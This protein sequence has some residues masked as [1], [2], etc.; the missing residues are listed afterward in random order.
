MTDATP[1]IV[2]RWDSDAFGSTAPNS[3][4]DGDGIHNTLDLRFPGQ[5]YDQ[6]TALH[7]NQ[8]RYYDPSGPRYTQSDPIVLRGG[9]NSYSY[10][11]NNPLFFV[12]PTGLRVACNCIANSE[13]GQY[14]PDP[15]APKGTLGRKRCKYQCTCSCGKCDGSWTPYREFKEV[16]ANGTIG[17][18]TIYG[19]NNTQKCIGQGDIV[20]FAPVFDAFTVSEAF[21]QRYPDLYDSLDKQCKNDDCKK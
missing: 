17:D 7:Y 21:R 1:K 14:F 20:N 3:D 13:G 19:W 9:L 4:P 6:E 15:S 10:A 11:L 2:W 5:I 8:A 18:T 12:D 16:T